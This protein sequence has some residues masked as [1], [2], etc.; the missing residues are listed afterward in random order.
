MNW[1]SEKQLQNDAIYEACEIP[2]YHKRQGAL[3][4][5]KKEE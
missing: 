1:S 2:V 4:L 5:L 3:W